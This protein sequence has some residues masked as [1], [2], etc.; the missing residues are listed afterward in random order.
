MDGANPILPG[1][2]E[3]EPEQHCN[4]C[5]NGESRTA[6]QEP[7][8]ACQAGTSGKGMLKRAG[9]NI[10]IGNIFK[11]QTVEAMDDDEYQAIT[12]VGGK[13]VVIDSDNQAD[14]S[15][16]EKWT[17]Q[18]KEMHDLNAALTS[19]IDEQKAIMIAKDE[20]IGELDAQMNVLTVP[21]SEEEK[22]KCTTFL[23]EFKGKQDALDASIRSLTNAKTQL[24][25]WENQEKTHASGAVPAGTA[26]TAGD[27]TGAADET[28][29]TDNADSP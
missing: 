27:D 21:I 9:T 7:R 1:M 26:A 2:P 28:T 15:S 4:G 17:K 23:D 10:R 25:G 22:D 11:Q 14:L 29:I 20:R 24:E 6:S 3:P 5:S 13:V 16:K 18:K 12:T 8:N 19:E